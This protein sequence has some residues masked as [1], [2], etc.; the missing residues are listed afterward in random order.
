M[1]ENLKYATISDIYVRDLT[2]YNPANHSE[3]IKF[4]KENNIT[5]LPGI[6]RKSCYR[7]INDDFSKSKLSGDLLCEPTD[8]LFSKS[9][10]NKFKTGNH[11]DVLFVM[12][13]KIIKGVVHVTDYNKSFVSFETYKLIY[14]F[15]KALR[16]Y[17]IDKGE[18][19]NSLL[20]WMK[21]KVEAGDIHFKNRYKQCVPEGE[22]LL[23][24][25]K[26]RMN[27]NP[28]QTFFL[29]DL[30]H[31]VKNKN[32][33][34]PRFNQSSIDSINYVRNW[35]AHNKDLTHIG[36]EQT[37]PI[38]QI[39]ELENFV[40]NINEFLDIFEHLEITMEFDK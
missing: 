8:L 17:L 6:D 9:T 36:E 26:R 37:F 18:S 21:N 29:N 40:K 35:V 10:L 23:I 25:Q 30:L 34:P 2:Y 24:E 11:D 5:Y 27:F 14:F 33:L 38:Y 7:F 19:N 31:F 12:E 28:F 15:E 4:C 3:L 13:G 20:N 22:E 32:Y 39:K 16:K 1:I